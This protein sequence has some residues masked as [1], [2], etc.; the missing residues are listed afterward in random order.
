MAHEKFLTILFYAI[1]IFVNPRGQQYMVTR[2]EVN[3]QT[4]IRRRITE[5]V[6]SYR[7]K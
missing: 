1:T 3:H 5:S 7:D 6:R 4:T 2:F